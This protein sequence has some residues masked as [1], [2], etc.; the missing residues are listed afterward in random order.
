[1]NILMIAPHAPP[2]NSAEAIQVGRYL[3]ELDRYHHVTL[4]T[5]PFEHGWVK[6]DVSLEIKLINTDVLIL[7]LPLHQYTS[8]LLSSRYFKYFSSPDKDFWIKFKA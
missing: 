8:R 4:I 3:K 7:T 5:T 2:K 1:M 6:K